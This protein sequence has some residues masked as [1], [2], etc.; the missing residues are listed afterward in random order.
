[1]YNMRSITAKKYLIAYVAKTTA[2]TILQSML[3]G[4]RHHEVIP[5][6]VLDEVWPHGD[7]KIIEVVTDELEPQTGPRGEPSPPP[8]LQR[9]ASNKLFG[10]LLNM[11]HEE[12]QHT[13][14]SASLL[15]T[16]VKHLHR[17][18]VQ[19]PSIVQTSPN[20][21]HLLEWIFDRLEDVDLS[22]FDFLDNRMVID[23]I[24]GNQHV[25]TVDISLNGAVTGGILDQLFRVSGL[26]TI[27]CIGVSGIQ[28]RHGREVL[29]HGSVEIISSSL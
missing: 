24:E 15:P 18:P 1:M 26:T 16:F 9:I 6:R 19:T 23:L 14:Q 25:R 28:M 29:T 20:G 2:T 11:P 7:W 22:P 21:L 10:E 4:S 27:I 12:M 13:L 17:Y 3:D 5:T 8:Q